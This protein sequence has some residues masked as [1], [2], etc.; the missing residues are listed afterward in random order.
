MKAS[1]TRNKKIIAVAIWIV[2]WQFAS[3]V[4]GEVLLLPS[5]YQT[6]AALFELGKT[7]I[8]YV[9]VLTT[10]I[11]VM[12]GLLISI[13]TGVALGIA[14]ARYSWLAAF[15]TP[16]MSTIKAVPVVSFILLL[17]LYLNSSTAPVAVCVLLCF[18]I[19]YT[20]TQ[21]GMLSI[22]KKLIQ[23]AE[24]HKVPS[25]KILTHIKI[26]AI[27]H[28]I[29]SGIFIC[30]GFSWKSVVTAEVLSAPLRSIGYSLYV[31]RMYVNTEE[32]FA[33]TLII[34]LLSITIE[35]FANSL[36]KNSKWYTGD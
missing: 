12:I 7:S 4:V 27:F 10:L 31:T 25:R 3:M 8:F 34:V 36:Y 26:P 30:I 18:P 35:H 6:L 16:M 32:L 11:R 15:L 29:L 17:V 23:M 21:K 13:I 2:I 1:I 24:L 14:S 9:S 19:M 22:D 5:P 28:Y 20:N 33:W